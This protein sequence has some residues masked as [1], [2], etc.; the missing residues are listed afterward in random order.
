MCTERIH[1][2]QGRVLARRLP[3]AGHECRR[4]VLG[5]AVPTRSRGP[6]PRRGKTERNQPRIPAGGN[7]RTTKSEPGV[8]LR[9]ERLFV[10]SRRTA[11]ADLKSR[12][13]DCRL[14]ARDRSTTPPPRLPGGDVCKTVTCGQPPGRA[15]RETFSRWRFDLKQPSSPIEQDRRPKP[16]GIPKA[17]YPAVH[18]GDM[19]A[20]RTGQP[21]DRREPL[22]VSRREAMVGM[23]IA[24]REVTP[25]VPLRRA[26]RCR[27]HRTGGAWS[28]FS[29]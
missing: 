17:I 19:R 11:T 24:N 25:G 4:S 12:P 6:I 5:P 13:R 20:A 14:K 23:L 28:V 8:T 22:L 26:Y 27:R 16:N 2:S 29:T 7:S 15:P 10:P 3:I 1:P 21:V 9:P 18:A